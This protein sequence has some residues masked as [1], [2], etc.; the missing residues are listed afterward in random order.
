MSSRELTAWQ[1]L[2]RIKAEEQRHQRDIADSGDG[3]VHY[4]G[5]D[6]DDDDDGEEDVTDGGQTE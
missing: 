3:I 1:S 4:Y 6:E 5:G 2:Y